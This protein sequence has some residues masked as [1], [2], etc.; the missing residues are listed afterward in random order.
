M[1]WTRIT[2]AAAIVFIVIAVVAV[3]ALVLKPNSLEDSQDKTPGTTSTQPMTTLG[4]PKDM[5][6]A[7]GFQA[8]EFEN[9][10]MHVPADWPVRTFTNPKDCELYDTPAVYLDFR[11]QG[12]GVDHDACGDDPSVDE[13][14]I[15]VLRVTIEMLEGMDY[16]ASSPTTVVNGENGRVVADEEDS[17]A[18]VFPGPQIMVGF[19][20][21]V[22]DRSVVDLIIQSL[23]VRR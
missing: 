18:I 10:T 3:L 21:P 22:G 6:L 14:S 4:Q 2:R 12:K 9:V 8:V 5:P 23:V 15:S 19:T 20:H 17:F 7:P 11:D 13:N 16:W 1:K